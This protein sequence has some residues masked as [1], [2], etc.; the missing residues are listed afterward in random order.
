MFL[1]KAYGVL[2]IGCELLR[3]MG[4]FKSWFAGNTAHPISLIAQRKI[5]QLRAC[6]SSVFQHLYHQS[7]A[8]V[9]RKA[10]RSRSLLGRTITGLQLGTNYAAGRGLNAYRLVKES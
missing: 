1:A 9:A 6:Y 4:H 7:P 2:A 5:A 10:D 8:Q 3:N